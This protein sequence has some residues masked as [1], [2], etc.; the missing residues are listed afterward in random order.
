MHYKAEDAFVC[1]ICCIDL[2][3]NQMFFLFVQKN[4]H[5]QDAL[6]A[7]KFIL[8]ILMQK[9]ESHVFAKTAFGRKIYSNIL[10]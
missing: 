7:S 10:I 1:E 8:Y 6:F 9:F 4:A 3:F 2:G 5:S